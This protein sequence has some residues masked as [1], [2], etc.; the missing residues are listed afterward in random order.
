MSVQRYFPMQGS[1]RFGTTSLSIVKSFRI[2]A[3]AQAATTATTETFHKGDMILGFQAKVTE[4]FASSDATSVQIGFTGKTMLSAS[5]T[6]GSFVANYIIGADQS[7]DAAVY[8]LTADDTFDLTISATATLT[9]G[10]LD[11]HV[12]YVPA[13]DGVCD[14][15]F[16]EYTTT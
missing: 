14:S 3:G 15:S 12:L 9:A 5:T 16:K 11:V 6:K 8:T 13:P 10:K 7:A 2:D 1:K 4:A